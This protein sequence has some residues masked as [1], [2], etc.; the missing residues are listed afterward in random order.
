MGG[1]SP[2]GV[3]RLTP[4][5]VAK[6]R[7]AFTV[8]VRTARVDPVIDAPLAARPQAGHTAAGSGD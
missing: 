8:L 5:A 2:G 4:Y 3:K 7:F 1:D 6:Q